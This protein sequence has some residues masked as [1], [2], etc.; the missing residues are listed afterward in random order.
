MKLLVLTAII[1]AVTCGPLSESNT[2]PWQV[3]KEYSYNVEAYT[4]T[5]YEQSDSYGNSFKALFMVRVLSPGRL[6]AKLE[7]PMFAQFHDQVT[8]EEWPT[9]LNYNP[10]EKFDHP[11]EIIVDG[12]RV[13]SLKLPESLSVPNE[14]LLK[15]LI[16]ALQADLSTYNHVD[17]F[18]NSYDKESFQGLFKKMESDVTGNCET[19]YSVAPVSADWHRELQDFVEDPIEITKSK[20][21]ESCAKFVDFNFGVP[22]GAVWKGMAYENEEKQFI[23]HTTES[24]LL[25][26][27]HG[28]IYKSETFDSAVVNPLLFGKQKAQVHSYVSFYLLS[29]QPESSKE[30]VKSEEYRS[31]DS[32]IFR[33]DPKSIIKANEKYVADAQKLL[34]EMTPLLQDP[35]I[36]PKSDFLSKYKSLIRLIMFM[37]PEQLAQL[38]NSI[39][40]A[41]SSK[42][43]VKNNMWIIYRD[44]VVQAGT[45]TAFQEIK[46]WIQS[47][48]VE[49][50]EAADVISSVASVLRVRTK[51]VMT[52][53]FDLAMSPEVQK[54]D[55]LNTTAL[56]A[57]SKFI[58]SNE[59]DSFLVEK[60][61]PRLSEELKKAIEIDDKNKAQV[62]VR[63]L[64]NLAHPEIL[65]VFAPYLDGHVPVT[66]YLRI[67]MV[68]SLKSLANT[69]D[70]YVRA[71]LF[72]L[73]KNTAEPYEIRV[74]AAL[75]IFLAFPSHEMMQIMAHMSAT[76]PSTQVRAVLANGIIF[77]A[78]LKDPRFAKLAKIAK[79][80]LYLVPKEKF[81]YRYSTE[82]LVDEYTSDDVAAH[83]RELSFIGSENH[84]LPVY[85]RGGLR[86]GSTGWT[87]EEWFTYSIS[88]MKHLMSY[89]NGM[90]VKEP[91]RSYEGVKFSSK[92][93]ADLLNIKPKHRCYLEGS[94]FLNNWNQQTLFTFTQDDLDA[95]LMDF[96][97]EAEKPPNEINHTNLLRQKQVFVTFPLSTGMLFVYDYSE[98]T[99]VKMQSQL[100]RIV[101]SESSINSNVDLKI[102]YA[103]NMDGSVGFFDA[104][105]NLYVSSGVINKFQFYIPLKV[106]ASFQLGKTK[107]SLKFE[108][109]EQNVNLAHMSV[110]PYISRYELY[111]PV[112]VLQDPSTKFIE[113]P[114]KV[115]SAP[116]KF[117][118]LTGTV[119]EFS[120]FSY[121][122]DYKKPL[123][124]FDADFLTNVRNL[125]YQKDVAYT[126]FDLKYLSKE[127]QNN[128]VAYNIFYGSRY[129]QEGTDEEMEPAKTMENITLPD[130]Y[131][132]IVKRAA[133]GIESTAKIQFL[134]ISVEFEGKKKREF[135][136]T[137]AV[138]NSFAEKKVHAA[139]FLNAYD[140]ING[141]FRMIEPQIAPLNFEEALKNKFKVKYEADIK[142]GKYDNIH[143]K[144]F[145]ER[146][147]KYTEQLRKDPLGKQCL[148]ETKRDNIY[149]KDC[150]KMII[151]AHAPDYFKGTLSYKALPADWNN[152]N[153]L[154]EYF[155]DLYN[156][157]VQVDKTR[158]INNNTL[159]I[160]SEAFYYD[161]YVNYEFASKYGVVQLNNV[162][163]LPYYQYAMANYAPISAWERSRNWF[164]DYQHLPFCSVDDNKIKTFSGREYEYSVTNAWHVVMVDKAREF[165]NDI[166]ILIRRE[167]ANQAVVYVSYK[168]AVGQA[169]EIE[170]TPKTIEVITNATRLSSSGVATYWN[171]V[172]NAP[173]LEYYTIAEDIEFFSINN[174]QVRF[175]YDNH[176]LVI[177][178]DDHRSSTWG[179]CGQSTSQISDDY[180]TPYGVV[181]L[182]NYYGASFSLEEEFIDPSTVELKKKAKLKAYHLSPSTPTFSALMMSGARSRMNL[183]KE[184]NLLKFIDKV[185]S[186]DLFSKQ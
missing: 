127:S 22:E 104:Y 102:L 128:A 34:Q 39:E 73:L 63:V 165:D 33:Y 114:E 58:A 136:F 124:L 1:A 158:A 78:R 24:R 151:K 140:Q 159:E 67:Q 139:W 107:F 122:N 31:V 118:E 45:Y 153:V 181:Y 143:F 76:D 137:S 125:L 90:F 134:D 27:K 36:L 15:G 48:R 144:G 185:L 72:S 170:I 126:S 169:V 71:V 168:T 117:G 61:I 184:R 152:W 172:T 23:K 53:F 93:I 42:N 50:D 149:L 111:S 176:R 65:K 40:V 178:T 60:V 112:T 109:P 68:I 59:D 105:S 14:N 174:G 20:N 160:V 9:G 5:N 81:G 49:G 38:T 138:A 26:G 85:Q 163:I 106:S 171:Y 99:V 52:E 123:S 75:N 56:L 154:Y 164:T 166:V 91:E 132:E 120:G 74:A 179:L 146:S 80:V 11:F 175:L 3:G 157:D 103:R 155:K 147:K 95:L 83:F 133:A 13:V 6:L 51:K 98:P 82:S 12:G 130:R 161:N 35:N 101:D 135:V 7:S 55:F 43:V 47:K 113:R 30:W 100:K 150:H 148:E 167:G 129:N 162:E 37:S 41:K 84:I 16:G 182:P 4:W 183:L 87:E 186:G 32:L 62:Y 77:A 115:I 18:P 94:F 54:Q 79:S 110:W 28:T 46:N 64:G 66:K 89:L 108:M 116:L 69:K 173:L 141:V 97:K 96:V 92:K 156:W 44:A 57:V 119:F 21:Y 177:F 29:F 131:E 86:F 10:V 8:K 180:I 70:E 19:L 17:N 25:V 121:S 88:D 2:W 142:F 145:E